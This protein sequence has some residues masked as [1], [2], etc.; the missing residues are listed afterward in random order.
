[1][2]LKPRLTQ[3]L[4]LSSH[5]S[6]DSLNPGRHDRPVSLSHRLEATPEGQ[7]KV[8]GDTALEFVV[9]CRLV[10]DPRV[11]KVKN[12]RPSEKGEL[13]GDSM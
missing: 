10:I 6:T 3:I 1:M 2:P 12:V 9:G 7:D 5:R 11:N 13:L 8:K 4:W